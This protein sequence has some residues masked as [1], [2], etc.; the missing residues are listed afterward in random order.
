M[1]KIQHTMQ[2]VTVLYIVAAGVILWLMSK[3]LPGDWLLH[4]VIPLALGL[5]VL[6]FLLIFLTLKIQSGR[7]KK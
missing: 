1:K 7:R 6:W 2:L 4:H 3:R 5:V